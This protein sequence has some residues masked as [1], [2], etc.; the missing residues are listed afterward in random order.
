L[1]EIH[2]VNSDF[3]R[4]FQENIEWGESFREFFKSL[5]MANPKLEKLELRNNKL[6]DD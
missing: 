3:V 2:L 1:Q 6:K 5:F 4:I